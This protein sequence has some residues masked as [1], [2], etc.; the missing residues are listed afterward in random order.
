MRAVSNYGASSS[1]NNNNNN[2]TERCEKLKTSIP[3]LSPKFD[4]VMSPA[5]SKDA[6][7][8]IVTTA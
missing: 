5:K 4:F 2:N 7:A 6:V 1:Y 3:H 8:V